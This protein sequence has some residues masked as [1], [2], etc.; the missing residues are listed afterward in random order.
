MPWTMSMSLPAGKP[1][2]TLLV[3]FS[4]T[5][6]SFHSGSPLGPNHMARDWYN[7]KATDQSPHTFSISHESSGCKKYIYHSDQLKKKGPW[8]VYVINRQ[9]FFFL[10]R[11]ES[12]PP[13]SVPCESEGQGNWPDQPTSLVV[14]SSDFGQQ[15]SWNQSGAGGCSGKRSLLSLSWASSTSCYRLYLEWPPMA[16]V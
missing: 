7:Q 8:D 5:M 13:C 12:W 3:S 2:L 6:A 10:L 16:H 15:K 1:S 11:K 14:R 4:W 9:C